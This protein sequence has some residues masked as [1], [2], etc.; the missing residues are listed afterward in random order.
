M[1]KKLRVGI[2]GCGN[3]SYKHFQAISECRDFLNLTGVYDINSQKKITFS[4]KTGVFIYNTLQEIIYNNDILSICTPHDSH[5]SLIKDIVMRN[6]FCICE[7]PLCIYSKHLY[8]LTNNQQKKVF[9]ILQNR[10]NNIVVQV[11]DIIRKNKLGRILYISGATRWYRDQNYYLES[12]WHG[13]LKKEGG[14]LYNQGIHLLDIAHWICNLDIKIST[15][16][17]VKKR[18]LNS[19]IETEDYMNIVM[20]NKGIPINIEISNCVTNKNYENS[21]L[22]VGDKAS[23]KIG[24]TH[25]DQLEFS[26]LPFFNILNNEFDKQDIYGIGHIDNYKAICNYLYENIESDSVCHFDEA[27][28]LIQKIEEIYNK[29]K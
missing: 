15:I 17:F 3:I 20:E 29:S 1:P 26:T 23:I 4:N 24:G 10:F 25:L 28:N 19:Q 18:L 9:C 16:E 14:I 13:K 22:I 7:K 27:I 21:I 2:I 11:R 5:N 8:N 6:K 12:S